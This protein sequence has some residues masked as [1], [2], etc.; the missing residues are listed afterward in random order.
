[1]AQ[2]VGLTLP[3]PPFFGTISDLPHGQ[4]TPAITQQRRAEV[5]QEDQRQ[6]PRRLLIYTDGSKSEYSVQ[7]TDIYTGTP[8]EE[9]HTRLSIAVGW[10]EWNSR[11]GRMDWK[12]KTQE[13]THY[14]LRG[15]WI[16]DR[17]EFEA[18][19]FAVA[20]VAVPFY[21]GISPSA[22]ADGYRIGSHSNPWVEQTGPNITEVAV[23]TDSN[24]A[25]KAVRTPVR[26]LRRVGALYGAEFAFR[27]LV[28]ASDQLIFHGVNVELTWIPRASAFGNI[29]VD[30]WAKIVRGVLPWV[31]L[32][33]ELY[34][35][36]PAHWLLWWKEMEAQGRLDEFY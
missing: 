21:K 28:Y 12:E 10:Q 34:F 24:N 22:D 5:Q 14:L 3:L 35:N 8:F 16:I 20:Y 27:R 11:T 2:S 31:E 19:K 15:T 9:W 25:L 18:L 13:M 26:S 7:K 4:A 32:Q 17:L 23:F 30:C 6:N 1:M 36:R 29:W 33:A